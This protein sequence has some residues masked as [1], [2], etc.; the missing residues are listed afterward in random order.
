MFRVASES[1]LNCAI[2]ELHPLLRGHREACWLVENICCN[3]DLRKRK[4]GWI[5]RCP[6]D[7]KRAAGE[8]AREHASYLKGECLGTVI[9]SYLSDLGLFG[10]ADDIVLC[11]MQ[12]LK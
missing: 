2:R 11:A 7:M 12:K 10:F 4:I 1:K 8:V 5:F 9:L 3:H 6:L